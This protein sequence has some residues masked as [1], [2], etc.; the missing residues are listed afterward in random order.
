MVSLC[1]T[2]KIRLVPDTYRMYRHNIQ[3]TKDASVQIKMFSHWHILEVF[4]RLLTFSNFAFYRTKV[5]NGTT[6]GFRYVLLPLILLF[7]S[8]HIY[9]LSYTNFSVS[10]CYS[11]T[12]R[13]L[14]ETF[15]KCCKKF[16]PIYIKCILFLNCC[17]L[18]LQK[19]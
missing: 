12:V 1:E 6:E 10:I 13:K 8:I 17:V 4:W 16:S 2:G 5:N 3:N 9:F 11:T 18:Y 14:I 15:S 7:I 19:M